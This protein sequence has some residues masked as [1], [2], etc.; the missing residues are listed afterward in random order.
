MG[1]EEN[2]DIFYSYLMSEHLLLAESNLFFYRAMK[3]KDVQKCNNQRD[4][5]PIF[6]LALNELN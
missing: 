6:A 3:D 1:S 5:I 2:N 4:I